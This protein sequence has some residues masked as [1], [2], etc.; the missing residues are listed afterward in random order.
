MQ[1]ITHEDVQEWAA[2]M[3]AALTPRGDITSVQ[4]EDGAV[5]ITFQNGFMLLP[6]ET[7]D[8][9]QRFEADQKRKFF[10]EQND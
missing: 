4:Q 2:Q 10:N 7:W 9:M 3:Q 8:D 1:K 5:L 6:Q